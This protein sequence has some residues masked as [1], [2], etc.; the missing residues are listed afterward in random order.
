MQTGRACVDQKVSSKLRSRVVWEGLKKWMPESVFRE[1]SQCLHNVFHPPFL[2]FPPPFL[3]LSFLL[4]FL[5][6][7]CLPSLLP[8]LPSFPLFVSFEM[9]FIEYICA[10]H[11]VAA[12]LLLSRISRVRLCATYRTAAHQAL[13]VPGFS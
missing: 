9:P 5:L 1:N 12:V 2:L 6:F 10:R 3:L 4:S 8:L 11:N 13:L 7:S